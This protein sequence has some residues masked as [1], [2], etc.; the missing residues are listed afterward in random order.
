MAHP[1]TKSRF[2][3]RVLTLFTR[4]KNKILKKNKKTQKF[5]NQT[6]GRSHP[7]PDDGGNAGQVVA[8]TAAVDPT[9]VG[10]AAA[11]PPTAAHL[12]SPSRLRPPQL[13]LAATTGHRAGLSALLLATGLPRTL[14]PVVVA[15]SRCRA[16]VARPSPPPVARSHCLRLMRERRGETD[17]ER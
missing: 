9:V 2:R 3:M 15:T 5:K 8:G 14:E 4:K 6:L 11:D 16:V 12:R 17:G 7:H 13:E 1:H 10:P